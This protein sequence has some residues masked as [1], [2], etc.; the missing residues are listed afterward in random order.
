[1]K[2]GKKYLYGFIPIIVLIQL[3]GCTHIW[4]ITETPLLQMGSPMGSV[5]PKTFAFKD[6]QDLRRFEDP[7]I[8]M[9]LGGHT[10]KIDQTPAA[11]VADRIKKEFE[12]NGHKCVDASSQTKADFIV[13]GVI[14]R[15]SVTFDR[16]FTGNEWFANAGVKL[17]INR[18]PTGSGI[19][20]K[21]YQGEYQAMQYLGGP[22][23]AESLGMATQRM[24]K[25]I[26]TD[27]ELIEFLKK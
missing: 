4:N 16:K 5:E 15:F 22:K 7:A 14:Y 19:F 3:V 12:R 11:F 25:D 20:L 24:F 13:D 9:E 2:T 21:S 26:S 27:P 10:H 17:T 18:V 8:I 23:F 6:F 1:M